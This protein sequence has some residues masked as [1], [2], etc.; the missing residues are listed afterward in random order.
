MTASSLFASK[1]PKHCGRSWFKEEE[2]T[3]LIPTG[4]EPQLITLPGL[5]VAYSLHFLRHL[6]EGKCVEDL[7]FLSVY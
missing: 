6:R 2:T 3:G 1:L 7:G 5:G 4:R